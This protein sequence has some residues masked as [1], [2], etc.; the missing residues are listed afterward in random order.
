MRGGARKRVG[1]REGE[2]L[3]DRFARTVIF[4]DK[5]HATV[6]HWRESSEYQQNEIERPVHREHDG[7]TTVQASAGNARARSRDPH[8]R[9]RADALFRSSAMAAEEPELE[10]ELAPDAEAIAAYG[11]GLAQMAGA[12]HGARTI[13]VHPVGAYSFGVKQARP[14]KDATVAEAMLR[15]KAKYEKEG[16][17][18]HVEAILLVNQHNHPHVLLLQ[19]GG[20]GAPATFRLPGG[21]LRHGEGEVEGLQRK[22]HNKLSPAEASLRKEWECLDC[23]ARWCRPGFE[24]N[25]YPYLPAHVTRPKNSKLLAVPLF[26]LYGNEARYGA[27]IASIPHLISRY[28]LNLEEKAE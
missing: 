2:R 25:Y 6:R 5:I 22:L 17:R 9:R 14:E 20:G 15:H 16:L 23:V 24:L 21:R 28:H 8:T 11:D 3:T 10:I 18:R 13:H 27:I 4:R 7:T 1:V 26:E 19:S 12:T